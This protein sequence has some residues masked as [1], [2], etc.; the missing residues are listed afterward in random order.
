M[1]ICNFITHAHSIQIIWSSPIQTYLAEINSFIKLVTGFHCP[2][3]SHLLSHSD[4]CHSL[5]TFSAIW[6]HHP[7]SQL[8]HIHAPKEQNRSAGSSLPFYIFR[9]NSCLSPYELLTKY[10]SSRY[11]AK[12]SPQQ[13]LFLIETEKMATR[14]WFQKHLHKVLC[15]SGI[16]SEHSFRIGTASTATRLGISDQTI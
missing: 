1:S 2:S 5:L 14:F 15:I 12:E 10:I 4:V 13:P 16:P 3:I 7:H 9:L 11:S 8:S 6:H